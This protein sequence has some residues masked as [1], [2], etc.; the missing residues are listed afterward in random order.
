MHCLN[1]VSDRR[2]VTR[3]YC[4]IRM[5]FNYTKLNHTI[6]STNNVT[7]GSEYMKIHTFELR[8]KE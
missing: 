6:T 4:F 2:F 7:V 8:K 3:D 5:I 1:E